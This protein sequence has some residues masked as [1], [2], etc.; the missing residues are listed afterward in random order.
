MNTIKHE[1]NA[2]YG[3]VERQFYLCKRFWKWELVFVIY[4]LVNAISIGFIVPGM[5]AMQG[6]NTSSINVDYMVLYLLT[7]SIIWG[8][9]SVI[10]DEVSNTITWERWEGT[11]EYTFMAPIE[12]FTHLFGMCIFS[13]L[14]GFIR[15]IL[16]LGIVSA[17]FDINL[18]NANFIGAAVIMSVA[19]LSFIGL[20]ILAAILPLLSPEKGEQMAMIIQALVLMVSG[21]YYPVT[22]L[23]E[24]MQF[25]SKFSPA[26]YA[27]EGMRMALIEGATISK[28]LP[29]II[30]LI[31]IAIFLIP[32]GLKIFSIGEVYAKKTGLLKRSG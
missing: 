17:F 22:I 24:W 7:G 2:A 12:R 28:L 23:P 27:L 9:L 10:F 13:I 30:P 15:T 14:Y 16:V 20:G 19:S 29:K 8:F 25:A 18:G 1:L 32:I 11:I 3:F 6:G 26:T 5:V 21:I 4:T 31:V